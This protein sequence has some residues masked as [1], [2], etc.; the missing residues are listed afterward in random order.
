MT[1]Y[2]RINIFITALITLL[3][4]GNQNASA[5]SE[6]SFSFEEYKTGN[7][8]LPYRQAI[9][10][11]SEPPSRLVIYLH[12]GTS[13]GNDN[14]SQL[15]EPAIDSIASF[16]S[17]KGLN[18]TFIVPQC[19]EN[20]SWGGRLTDVLKELIANRKDHFT[21]I[22]DVYIF[23]GSM[24]GTGTWTM[25]S[26]FPQLFSAAMPV[27]GN[28]SKCDMNNV[29]QTPLFTVMGTN[30]RIMNIET[31]NDLVSELDLLGAK[32]VY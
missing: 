11:E 31:V 10:S 2:K 28:P 8:R 30:D 19:P 4:C 26:K 14:I 6:I 15:N 12:G 20:D 22:K 13:K 16:I 5:Q 9:I 24:G 7:I 17:K 29:S 23:G 25:I 21:T 32:Y 27:A 18:S 1:R 3:S